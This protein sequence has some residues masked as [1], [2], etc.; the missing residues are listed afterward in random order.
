MTSCLCVD[1]GTTH[2]F[3]TLKTNDVTEVVINV[4]SR[5]Y[6]ALKMTAMGQRCKTFC[7]G[8]LLPFM[9]KIKVL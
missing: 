6:K 8:N 1:V 5:E 7:H 9:V 3:G 2:Y 4:H